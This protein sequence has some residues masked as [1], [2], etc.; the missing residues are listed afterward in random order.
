MQYIYTDITITPYSEMASDVL[1]AMLG[2]IGF[3]SFEMTDT[4]VKAYI[5][6]EQFDE[7]SLKDT[8]SNIFLP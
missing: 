5:P 1:T 2:D 6:E 7:E 8:L 3:D 4:G